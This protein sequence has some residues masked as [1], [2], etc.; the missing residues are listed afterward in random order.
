MS[1]EAGNVT[2]TACFTNFY[3]MVLF[4]ESLCYK[5]IWAFHDRTLAR[6]SSSSSKYQLLC[7]VLKHLIHTFI[8]VSPSP[9]SSL[10]E[11]A[12]FCKVETAKC[13][14]FN[15]KADLHECSIIHVSL[16]NLSNQACSPKNQSYFRLKETNQILEAFCSNNIMSTTLLKLKSEG[17]EVLNKSEYKSTRAAY[18]STMSDF[19]IQ[20]KSKENL[21]KANVSSFE[22]SPTCGMTIFCINNKKKL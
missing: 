10:I 3:S 4:A 14:F 5:F 18:E 19:S 15:F 12:S 17:V 1:F 22:S 21:Q 11:C 2:K 6:K 20:K 9:C 13:T 16:N 8:I 7:W